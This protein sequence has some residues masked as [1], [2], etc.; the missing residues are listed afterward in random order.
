MDDGKLR[1]EVFKVDWVPISIGQSAEWISRTTDEMIDGMYRPSHV[2]IRQVG[3]RRVFR[4]GYACQRWPL[5][6]LARRLT[7]TALDLGIRLLIEPVPFPLVQLGRN[8]GL[9]LDLC[10][11]CAGADDVVAR[12]LP[13]HS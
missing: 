4:E 3:S 2:E 12:R 13:V 10:E 8:V 9:L 6:G 5:P 11:V 7:K 1:M